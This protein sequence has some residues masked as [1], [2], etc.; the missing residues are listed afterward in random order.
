MTKAR[1]ISKLSAVEV[2]A[3]ATDTTN[4]TSS[5]A[6]MDSE[7]TNIAAIKALNQAVGTGDG[8]TFAS[9][10]VDNITI[11]GSA[12][13]AG[14]SNDFTIDTVGDIILDA[15]GADIKFKD[16]GTEFGKIQQASNNLRIYS[17]ISDADIEIIGNDGGSNVTA[18]RFDMST[19]GTAYFNHDVKLTDNH[20]LRLGTDSDI[21]VYHDN[22]N[23]YLQNTTGNLTI[24]VAGYLDIDVDNGSVYIS[25][26]G[27]TF[28]RLYNDSSNLRIKSEVND[29]DIVF[30][31]VDN[32]STITALTLDMSE[33]GAATFSGTVTSTG[34]IGNATNFD[35]IQNT[36]DGS[37]SKRTRIGGGGDVVSSRGAMV[38][39]SGNEHGNGGMLFLHA[40]NGGAYSQIR[41]YTAGTERMRIDSS[42]NVVINTGNLQIKTIG[43][44]EDNGTR[45]LLRSTGDASGLRFDGGG[46]TPFKNGSAAN[47]T[48]DLGFS[49]GQFKDL[50]L[51][52][53]A[54]V[55][56]G[57]YLSGHPVVGVASFDSGYATRLGSTGS[58]TVNATQ[59]YAGGSVQATFKGGNVGIGTTSLDGLLTIPSANSDTVPRI[60][61]QHPST[62]TD[63]SIDTF[64]DASGTYL[65]IG[66]N[67]YQAANSA[68]SK[69]NTNE[70]ATAL[71]FDS[72]GVI[73]L[74]T[75]SSSENLT[76]RMRVNSN[77][78][79]AIGHS[80]SWSKL[81]ITGQGTNEA[82]IFLHNDTDG[83]GEYNGIIFKSDS[84]NTNVRKKAGIFF[85]RTAIRG[86]GTLHFCVEASNSDT[87]VSLSHSQLQMN[88]DKV[89]INGA[90][91]DLFYINGKATATAMGI[92]IGTNGYN[93]IEFDNATGSL[94]GRIT[95]NS[96]TTAYITSSDY[97][98]KENVADM[99]GATTRLK[100]L[101][102]KRFNWIADDTNT[103][104]DGFLAHEVS[105]VVPEAVAGEKDAVHPDGHHEAGEI[106][107]QG[108]DH[109]KLV[110]LL[111]KTIQELEARITALEA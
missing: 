101:K 47:G 89:S 12:I 109:S 50:Y 32:S 39:M 29:K 73:Q 87:N 48:V 4:V 8:P 33:G 82:T 42:G 72:G 99:T 49:G 74:Y 104:I 91:S 44:I 92:K 45:L 11:D 18:L 24:D 43:Q 71:R 110:P 14:A 16:G 54:Y 68:L 3:D 70:E 34:L 52:N 30:Q 25:D 103:P 17:S 41:S 97:R 107:P 13:T 19:Q 90:G 55:G 36:S 78:Y 100:Q 5:G 21:I 108:I 26:G 35:I 51:S 93:G 84:T 15:D 7:L 88:G 6:L 23:A 38:E 106:D 1:D 31:G 102:P 83:D 27:T 9:V 56:A 95:I 57:V 67:S 77:G 10:V 94:V 59:I 20:A 80:D 65:S 22:S 61:L 58:S 98:L 64:Q 62:T 81:Q 28:A 105:S 37:D 66:S 69:F 79:V 111:V 96:G 2:D 86:Q 76:E 85:E 63:A 46:Y 75:A 53:I 40:G 60:R